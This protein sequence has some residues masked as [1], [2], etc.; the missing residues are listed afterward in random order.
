MT[1][2]SDAVSVSHI[3]DA[4]TAIYERVKLRTPSGFNGS[5]L[6]YAELAHEL[7]DDLARPG[8]DK[9]PTPLLRVTRGAAES[10]LRRDTGE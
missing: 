4:K 1:S 7:A 8:A 3:H 6:H 5:E 9:P 2:N 10:Q